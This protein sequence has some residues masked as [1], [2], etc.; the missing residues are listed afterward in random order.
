VGADG[1]APVTWDIVLVSHNSVS[2]LADYW[3]HRDYPGWL[4]LVIVEN[5]FAR[6]PPESQGPGVTTVRTPNRGLAAANN[7]GAAQGQAPYLLFCN[8][9]VRIDVEDLPVLQAVLD[10]RGGLVAPRLVS[11]FG[12]Q[13]GNGRAFPSPAAQ[14]ANRLPFDRG[15]LGRLK[16]GYADPVLEGEV[17]E[18]DWLIGACIAVRRAD[19]QILGG[20]DERF[21]L[22]FEDTDLCLRAGRSGLPVSVVTTLTWTHSWASSS[23]RWFS[24]A[25]RRHV[26]SA[27]TFYRR[28]PHLVWGD[29]AVEGAVPQRR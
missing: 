12:V 23:R 15:P 6:W 18:V 27:V 25:W 14:L 9:D 4:H 28:Y 17:A 16:R 10:E 21:F 29:R 7:V 2:D 11:E 13:Q 19:L 3:L 26:R 22:Y 5:G 24:R 8:P 1:S 20:W